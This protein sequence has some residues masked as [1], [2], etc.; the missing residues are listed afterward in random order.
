MSLRFAFVFKFATFRANI[1]NLR[2]EYIWLVVIIQDAI[3]YYTIYILINTA[4]LFW[5]VRWF[6]D[7]TI[8]II[9]IHEMKWW[10]F[11]FPLPGLFRFRLF[12]FVLLI[13]D[14][15]L[16]I[17]IPLLCVI[18]DYT[19]CVALITILYD[20]IGKL[21]RL[22]FV[23]IWDLSDLYNL[24]LYINILIYT[25]IYIQACIYVVK[26]SKWNDLHKSWNIII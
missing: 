12:P 26:G 9:I 22:L 11:F 10:L 6:L 15:F 13:R 21:Q 7:N 16:R 8:I 2:K 3:K 4:A 5:C 18:A 24:S 1:S 25:Y 23:T 20:Y 19:R 17:P 14:I